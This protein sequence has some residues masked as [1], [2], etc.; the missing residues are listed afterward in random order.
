[1]ALVSTDVGPVGVFAGSLATLPLSRAHELVA[2][3]ETLG[4]G[5]VWLPDGVG[6]A[7]TS[8]ALLLPGGDRIVLATGIASI[9]GRDP[10]TTAVCADRLVTAFPDRFLLGLGVSHRVMVEGMRHQTYDRPLARMRE[11]LDEMDTAAAAIAQFTQRMQATDQREE[12]E[13]AGEAATAATSA[14]PPR[15]LGALGPGMLQLAGERADGAHS[16]LTTPE[17]T[18]AARATLGPNALLAPLQ[19]VVLE[20]DPTTARAAGRAALAI[21]LQL[22]NYQRHFRRLGFGDEMADGGSDHLV[23]TFVMWG[24]EGTIKARVAE[25]HA[26]GADHLALAVSSETGTVAEEQW[27]ALAPALLG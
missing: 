7:I 20:S 9:W 5:A 18:A 4:Y 17:H 22:E 2:E 10:F 14:R 3:L 19:L 27:H 11:Y 24:D 23:D 12:I 21:Y 8:S 26:A 25:L 16:F 13:R 6:D 15:V 1:V